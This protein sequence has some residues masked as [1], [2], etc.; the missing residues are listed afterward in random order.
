M[1]PL[2]DVAPPSDGSEGRVTGEGSVVEIHGPQVAGLVPQVK[3]AR[4]E[5]TSD[6]DNR[7]EVIP[8]SSTP[9]EGVGLDTT[10]VTQQRKVRPEEGLPE[11]A[12]PVV[13]GPAEET[14]AEKNGQEG[15]APEDDAPRARED[16]PEKPVSK[17]VT[18][19]SSGSTGARVPG[20]LGTG[21][22]DSAF[23]S[24]ARA[25]ILLG[26]WLALP[27]EE[28]VAE[29]QGAKVSNAVDSICRA[30]PDFATFCEIAKIDLETLVGKFK[31]DD[32]L[33][34]T[35][36]VLPGL[37]AE[38]VQA[39][40]MMKALTEQDA[41]LKQVCWRLKTS[42]ARLARVLVQ[43]REL[44]DAADQMLTTLSMAKEDLDK[45]DMDVGL[46]LW[47]EK[48]KKIRLDRLRVD[49]LHFSDKIKTLLDLLV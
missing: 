4:G 10:D 45:A 6:V 46:E 19:P 22:S 7:T 34:Q 40:G 38:L 20:G 48:L 39:K 23:I 15:N 16:E 28:K 41:L 24:N 42:E 1:A 30:C 49:V 8:D 3:E 44:E 25:K 27:L 12:I 13:E 11:E 5:G 29:E 14:P 17:P 32:P 9:V 26:K 33:C 21:S 31:R 47:G 35:P 36:D 43:K 18:E 2:P 37:E